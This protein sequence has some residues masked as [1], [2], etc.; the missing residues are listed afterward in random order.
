MSSDMFLQKLILN[1]VDVGTHSVLSLTYIERLNLTCPKLIMKIVDR[2]KIFQDNAKLR[3]GA[4]MEVTL[5]DATGR[6]EEMF[7]DRFVVG[8]SWEVEDDAMM[9]EALQVDIDRIKQPVSVPMF[10]IN[11][12]VK[13]ILSS[14]FP[15]HEVVMDSYEF[16]HTYHVLTGSTISMMLERLKWDAGAEIYLFRGKVYFTKLKGFASKPDSFQFDYMRNSSENPTIESYQRF[17]PVN[18]V[19]RKESRDYMCWDIRRGMIGLKTGKPREYLPF[20]HESQ[21]KNHNICLAKV[22]ECTLAGD[23]RFTPSMM[24]KFELNRKLTESVIDESVP[25]SQLMI[26][27]RHFQ[28]GMKYICVCEFGEVI[29]AN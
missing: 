4:I 15:E 7:K 8:A 16:K 20:T 6:G 28:E 27:V 19:T 29:D 10:F 26:G 22:M 3:D 14:V 23:G 12:T 21:I 18:A 9:V 17:N 5:G 2:D 25:S 24:I 13:Q 11:K 1:D